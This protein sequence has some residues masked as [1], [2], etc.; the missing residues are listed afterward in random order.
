MI[1][2]PQTQRTGSAV[3][4]PRVV[5]LTRRTEYEDLLRRFGTR[6]QAAFWLASRGQD[7]D[8]VCERHER[9]EAA[10]TSVSAAL[11]HRWRRTGLSREDLDRFLFSPDDIIVAIGQDGLVANVA[12]YLSGQPVIGINPDPERF[13]GVLVPHTPD[14]ARDLLRDVGAERASVERRTMARAVLDDGQELL[15]LNELFIGHQSHQSARYRIRIAGRQERHSSSGVIITTGTGATG[16]AR[17][18][19]A[20]RKRPI[21][22]P[23]PQDDVLGF[24][25]REAWPSVATGTSLTQGLVRSGQAI[26]LIS[27]QNH[28]GVIFGDGIENDRL[29]FD[30]GRRVRIRVAEAKLSLVS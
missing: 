26:E 27:E 16:W 17:S 13:E 6:A 21:R 8:Q 15:A 18:I 14:A 20:Q 19:D 28:G 12:K 29:T 1:D 24:Y 7:L 11:P 9:E 3:K 5:I 22:L 23:G 10:R 2:I 4:T 30:W 25:V